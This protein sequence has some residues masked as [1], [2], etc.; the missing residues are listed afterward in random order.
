M[1]GQAKKGGEVGV[2]GEHYKGGQ[3]MPGSSKTKKGDRASNGGPSSRPKR[4]LIE[5]GVFV[6]VFEGEKTIFRGITAFVVVENG[7]MRQSASDKAVANYGLTD[8]LPGLIERF[9]AG[10]RYR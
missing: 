8:T 10:E 4:Q 1:K 3:F 9:N 5:P 6:E 7:V 2:N